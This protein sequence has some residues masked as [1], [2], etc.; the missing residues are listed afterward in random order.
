M[1]LQVL[2]YDISY[3]YLYLHLRRCKGKEFTTKR[4]K[5]REKEIKLQFFQ[6][7][8]SKITT[9]YHRDKLDHSTPPE[10]YELYQN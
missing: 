10:L 2:M 5:W 6:P 7:I 1:S 8:I 3:P 4:P 9:N